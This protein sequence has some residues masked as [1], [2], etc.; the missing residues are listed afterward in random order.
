MSGKPLKLEVVV[1]GVPKPTVCWFKDDQALDKNVPSESKDK[2]HSISFAELNPSNS[3]VYK[4][5]AENEAGKAE[6]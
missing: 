6:S 3:G 4:A 1:N 5:V 2:T